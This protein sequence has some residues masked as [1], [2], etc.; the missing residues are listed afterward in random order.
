MR[1]ISGFLVLVLFCSAASAQ[2]DITAQATW[3]GNALMTKDYQTFV[4]YT[5]PA[6]MKQMGGRDKMAEAIKKQMQGIEEA[7]SKI[8]ALSYKNPTT[9]ITAGKELQ[10]TITQEMSLQVKGG[11]V[12]AASTLIAISKDNG[13]HWYFVDAG[14]R[15]ISAV[16]ASMPNISKSL[17]LPPPQPPRLLQ[18]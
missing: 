4:N 14:D 9:P 16:R 11:K 1:F 13:A 18:E 3:M 12:L 7:G 6:I 8:I 17:T 10:C 5:Y 15:D 2:G